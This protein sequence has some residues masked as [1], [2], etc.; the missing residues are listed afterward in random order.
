MRLWRVWQESAVSTV[1]T[2]N[3]SEQ[4]SIQSNSVKS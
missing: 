1:T 2:L 4:L 3:G